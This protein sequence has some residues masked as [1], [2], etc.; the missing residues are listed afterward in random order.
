MHSSAGPV[1]QMLNAAKM[2]SRSLRR[3]GRGAAIAVALL[4]LPLAACVQETFN[5]GYVLTP[6]ALTQVPIGASRE[7]VL[8]ALGTPTTTG[9]LAGEAFY[10]ISEKDERSFAFM[11]PTAVDRRVLAV[12]FDKDG[13][14][15]ELAEYGLQDGKVFDFIAKKTPTG[16]A[17]YGFIGQVLRGVTRVGPSL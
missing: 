7:Q 11:E 2:R 1:T 4:A 15:R 12:Y 5:R 8:L 17:D 9:T 3:R 16:G 10:Y 13:R 6:E 14:V